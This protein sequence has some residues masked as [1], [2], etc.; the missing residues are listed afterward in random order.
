MEENEVLCLVVYFS[1]LT[2][3]FIRIIVDICELGRLH[4]RERMEKGE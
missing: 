3:G 2:F 4:K 1:L